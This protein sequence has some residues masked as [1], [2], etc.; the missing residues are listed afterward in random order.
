MTIYF[1]KQMIIFLIRLLHTDIVNAIKQFR[2]VATK[3]GVAE[4][5]IGRVENTMV[6]HLKSWGELEEMVP[7]ICEFVINGHIYSLNS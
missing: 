4:Q 2:V 6:D 1:N 7:E 3:Y 5:W